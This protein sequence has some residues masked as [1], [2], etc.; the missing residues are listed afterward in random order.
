MSIQLIFITQTKTFYTWDNFFFLFY[1]LFCSIFA[2]KKIESLMLT[3]LKHLMSHCCFLHHP[4]LIELALID[5]FIGIIITLFVLELILTEVRSAMSHLS[6]WIIYLNSL[7]LTWTIFSF[8]FSVDMI[9]K[10]FLNDI[11][12]KLT[13]P[14]LSWMNWEYN[15]SS[16]YNLRCWIHGDRIH[17][18]TSFFSK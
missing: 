1:D 16:R 8:L 10:I 4:E 12:V 5:V 18:H 17:L 11:F 13:C 15:S 7:L 6:G 14:L 9:V 3:L 2:Q